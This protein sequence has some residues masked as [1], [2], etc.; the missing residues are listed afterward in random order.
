[1]DLE[2]A[3]MLVADHDRAARRIV[4][5]KPYGLGYEVEE[6]GDGQEVLE[7]LHEGELPDLLLIT[8]SSMPRTNGLQLVRRLRESDDRVLYMLPI[9]M[10][11]ARRSERDVV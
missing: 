10:V 6:A 2:G 1:M 4:V 8:A 11:S 3:G 7:L 5:A 9:I